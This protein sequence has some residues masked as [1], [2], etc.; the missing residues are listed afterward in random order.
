MMNVRNL[1]GTNNA[2]LASTDS[3]SNNLGTQLAITTDFRQVDGSVNRVWPDTGLLWVYFG[4]N[5]SQSG[6]P[7]FH[8]LH[9]RVNPQPKPS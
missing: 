3:I 2:T 6:A 1:F 4:L 9:S 5:R 7:T 8:S